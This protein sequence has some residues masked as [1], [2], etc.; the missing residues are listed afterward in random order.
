MEANRTKR[1][2]LADF[3]IRLFLITLGF[4]MASVF[5]VHQAEKLVIQNSVRQYAG[6]AQGYSHSLRKSGEARE[7]LESLMKERMYSVAWSLGETPEALTAGELDETAK[8]WDVY[9][10]DVFSDEGLL[11]ASNIS[12]RVGWNIPEEHP[13]KEFLGGGEEQRLPKILQDSL[14]GRRLQLGFF[15]LPQG[16]VIQV[17]ILADSL[18]D[19]LKGFDMR[20][21]LLEMKTEENLAVAVYAASDGKVTTSAPVLLEGRNLPVIDRFIAEDPLAVQG[22][23]GNSFG[24]KLFQVFVPVLVDGKRVG[25]IGIGLSADPILKQVMQIRVAGVLGLLLLFGLILYFSQSVHRRRKRQQDQICRDPG[26]GLYHSQTLRKVLPRKLQGNKGKPKALLLLTSPQVKMVNMILGYEAG[27]GILKDMGQ[28]LSLRQSATLIPYRFTSDSFVLYAENYGD[29]TALEEEAHYLIGELSQPYRLKNSLKSLDLHIGIAEQ[30][31]EE[32]SL[33]TLL[34]EAAVAL[35]SL[36]G[37]DSSG[38]AFYGREMAVKLQRMADVEGAIQGALTGN[39]EMDFHLVYQPLYSLK[40]DRIMGF[41]ALARLRSPLLGTIPPEEFIQSAEKTQL[42]APLG[43]KVLRE[44]LAFLGGLT[45]EER[46]G[47]IMAVNISVLQLIREEF[48]QQVQTALTQA[49]LAPEQLELEITESV[50]YENYD[51]VNRNL[52]AL[53][54]LGIRIS[55]DDFGT[56]YSSLHRLK[57]LQV[58]TLKI[59]RSFIGVIHDEFETRIITK[60]IIA[61]AHQ[62]GLTV[63]A[64]GVEEPRQMEYL[65]MNR[66]DILQGYLFSGPLKEKEAKALLQANPKCVG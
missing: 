22:G 31:P 17:G 49:G 51:L 3:R 21:I 30:G 16:R 47:L 41:E 42:I 65:R 38:F 39:P 58:D 44:A 33:E 64:E 62:L 55:L 53:R 5:F 54:K 52:G 46:K 48:P 50:L 19:F 63:V 7:A 29:R 57:E 34:Q 27:E 15:R 24:T 60:D 1:D 37:T 6:I 4:F 26:T 20:Q 61:M 12:S 9:L 36:S 45:S 56:G 18:E 32:Q 11:L 8:N 43:L 23:I 40:E 66:C 10:I 59:D 13:L 2:A 28:K 14:S 25:T 35:N